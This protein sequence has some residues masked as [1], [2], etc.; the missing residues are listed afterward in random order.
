MACFQTYSCTTQDCPEECGI[1][2]EEECNYTED[3]EEEEE[4]VA[5]CNDVNEVSLC[6]CEV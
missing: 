6:F 4:C 1:V 2:E 5:H 3:C